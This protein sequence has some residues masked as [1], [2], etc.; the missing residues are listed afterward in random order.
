MI[1]WLLLMVMAPTGETD[2]PMFPRKL[3]FPPVPDARVRFPLP[4]MVFEKVM[5]W[6]AAA[7]LKEAVPESVT[8]PAME[9]GWPAVTVPER[10]TGPVALF[11]VS[12]PES[13]AVPP[14]V[15]VPLFVTVREALFRV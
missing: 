14:R 3:I 5:V 2:V 11:C 4:A 13:V 7:V 12:A 9:I 6:F 15:K 10:I 8:G 1:L